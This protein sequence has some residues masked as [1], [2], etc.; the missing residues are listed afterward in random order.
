MLPHQQKNPPYE[1]SHREDSLFYGHPP[2]GGAFLLLVVTTGGKS[3]PTWYP[4]PAAG[5]VRK[6]VSVLT[7]YLSGLFLYILQSCD[8]M[9]ETVRPT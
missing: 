5:G 7:D 2:K 9:G 8:R 3:S 6:T 4:A 1:I